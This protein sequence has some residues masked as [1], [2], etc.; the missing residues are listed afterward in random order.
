M[1]FALLGGLLGDRIG[2]KRLLY[3]ASMLGAVGS[4][5]LMK[6]RT[7]ET[8][9]LYGSVFGAGIGLF[10]TSNW[11]LANILAPSERAGKYLG[12]SNLATAGAGAVARLTGPVVDAINN[13]WAGMYRGYTLLF[14]Y[15]NC[16]KVYFSTSSWKESPPSDKIDCNGMEDNPVGSLYAFSLKGNQRCQFFYEIQ[17]QPK[18]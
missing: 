3:I 18:F 7:P 17:E 15:C 4:L 9:L 8:L 11:A 14:I 5:L 6:A 13:E 1:V 12:F 2:H 10:L 16:S